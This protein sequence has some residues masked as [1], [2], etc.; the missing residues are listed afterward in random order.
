MSKCYSS[1]KSQP[2]DFKLFLNFLHNGLH[3]TAFGIFEILKIDILTNFILLRLHGTQW[4]RKFQNASPLTNRRQ[5]VLKLVLNFQ[6]VHTT[7]RRTVKVAKGF[8]NMGSQY[9]NLPVNIRGLRTY[10]TFK[11][12]LQKS[13]FLSNRGST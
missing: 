3:K 5:K 1:Y 10:G 7:F 12:L 2:K 9:Y 8:L 6:N 13:H 4:E 11:K